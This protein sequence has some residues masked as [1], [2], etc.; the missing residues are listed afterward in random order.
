M[1][2]A[3]FTAASASP[4]TA[5]LMQIT[6]SASASP[7]KAAPSN[8]TLQKICYYGL[9]A[10]FAPTRGAARFASGSPPSA[11]TS[12]AAIASSPTT[13]RETQAAIAAAAKFAS[14]ARIC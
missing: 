8:P 2:A 14:L 11:S 7:A 4:A 3:I 10:A 6:A 5:S 1:L 9:V 13:S 12:R